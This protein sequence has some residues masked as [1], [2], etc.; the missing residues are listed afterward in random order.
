M[1]DENAGESGHSQINIRNL[2][3]KCG[4]CGQYQTLAGFSRRDEWNVYAYEC[5]N[6]ICDPELSRTLLEVPAALDEFARRDPE[7]RG[8]RRHSAGESD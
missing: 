5:E 7:W 6:T 3:V 1:A 2:S 4:H 8:G